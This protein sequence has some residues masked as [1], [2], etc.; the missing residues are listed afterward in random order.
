MVKTPRCLILSQDTEQ[1]NLLRLTLREYGIRFRL[2]EKV[3]MLGPLT[4]GCPTLAWIIDLDGIQQNVTE[5]SA[6]ARRITPDSKLVFLSSSF[7][8]DLAQECLREQAIALLA[9][10]LQIQR[11]VQCISA[12]KQETEFL[13]REEFITESEEGGPGEGTVAQGGVPSQPWTEETLVYKTCFTCPMCTK[14]FDALRFKHWLLPVVD[15]G[16]DFCPTYPDGVVPELFL[17][18]V[19]PECLYANQV[20]RFER[21]FPKEKE[22]ETFLEAS[23]RRHRRTL[24][25]N[26]D[27]SGKRGFEEGMKSLEL[28]GVVGTDLQFGD[29]ETFYG[30]LL[31]KTSWLCRRMKKSA[32]EQE[33]QIAALNHYS[34]LYRPYLRNYPGLQRLSPLGKG[35]FPR[36]GEIQA[37]LPRGKIPLRD[38]TVIVA[39]FLA[40]ELSRR[41]SR[42]AEAEFYF[43]ETLQIP[44]ISRFPSLLQQARK[45]YQLLENTPRVEAGGSADGE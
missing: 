20:G 24:V 8:L 15:V 42:P 10:P 2:V 28:A 36:K 30:E 3:E 1:F 34:E 41:L 45:A 32:K 9:K 6:M 44:F 35:P 19:C 14:K 29:W 22:R 11:L 40:A 26:L 25:G 37:R 4:S 7:T 18:S 12:F 27:L 17:I 13:E 23:R 33:A 21:Y 16:L 5:I 38:R 39:G 31:L 43:L